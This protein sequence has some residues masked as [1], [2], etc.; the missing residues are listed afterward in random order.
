MYLGV[1]ELSRFFPSVPYLKKWG[2]VLMKVQSQH[3]Q[4][5]KSIQIL[6]WKTST[7]DQE[8]QKLK[9]NN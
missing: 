2:L 6:L 5:F 9:K 1:T 8:I 3:T 7:V 4:S